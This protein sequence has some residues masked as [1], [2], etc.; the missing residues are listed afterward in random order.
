M[1]LD[2]RG[3][4]ESGG[5]LLDEYLEQEQDDAVEAIAWIAFAAFDHTITFAG[6]EW[7][8]EIRSRMRLR[9]T[10]R[11]FLLECDLDVYEGETRVSSRSW[12]P[13]IARDLM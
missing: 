7:C 8:I 10:P 5:V 1:R 6:D 2:I 3:S 4:G 13:V 9:S 11:E 12:T